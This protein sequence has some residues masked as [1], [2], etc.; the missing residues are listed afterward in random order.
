MARFTMEDLQRLSIGQGPDAETYQN[1]D[2]IDTSQ[3]L[4]WYQP[5]IYSRIM[6]VM[7]GGGQLTRRQIA[8]KLGLKKTPWLVDRI[9]RLVTE[10]HL[11]RFEARTPQ[12]APVYL[13]EV[14]R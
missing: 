12:G 9:D 13:Y 2:S 5:T 4:V 3:H 6:D 1:Q 14:K 11:E 10:G 8:D 7:D